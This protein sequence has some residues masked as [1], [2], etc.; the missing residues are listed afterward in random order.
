MSEGK[1]KD[2]GYFLT[3]DSWDQRGIVL[4]VNFTNPLMISQGKFND[5][6]TFHILDANFFV[7]AETGEVLDLEKG[8][9]NP[10]ISIPT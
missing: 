1:S 5:K 9:P 2:L 10:T 7:S 4:S 6:V 3:V 8:I